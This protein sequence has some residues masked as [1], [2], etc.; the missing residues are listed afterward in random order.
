MTKL[1]KVAICVA[2]FA[3]MM[4]GAANAGQNA[5][6][7]AKIYWLATTTA[8]VGTGSQNSTAA[9]V[10]ALVTCT[11]LVNFRGAD[12]QLVINAFDAS[13]LPACWQSFPGG[14]A[15]GYMAGK[16][17]G[18]KS[19]SSTIWPNV[20]TA[21]PALPNPVPAQ[22][23]SIVLYGLTGSSSC[24]TPHNTGV[25]W[26]SDA[27]SSGVARTTTREYGVYGFTFDLSLCDPPMA[28]C[29]NPN[30]RLGCG[31]GEKGNVMVVVD[32]AAVKDYYPFTN[33]FQYLTWYGDP[34][35]PGCPLSTP[36]PATTWGKVKKL[37]R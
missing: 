28:V 19:G 14:Y 17:G 7:S 24:V 3:T 5:G 35:L 8:T 23:G 33:G 27:G 16:I 9:S 32:G 12:V 4:V 13:G 2:L 30:W 18:W 26:L 36:T 6:G 22:D 29:I 37:Y 31:S 21:S 1:L 15:E 11:G 20:F 10:V 25:I 34:T